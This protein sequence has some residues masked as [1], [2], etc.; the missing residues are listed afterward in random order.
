MKSLTK[1]TEDIPSLSQRPG[2]R[3]RP[4]KQAAQSK[5]PALFRSKSCSVGHLR[6]LSSA[7]RDAH[8]IAHGAEQSRRGTAPRTTLSQ[9]STSGTV[10]RGFGALFPALRLTVT[11]RGWQ[12]DT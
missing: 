3:A 6:A 8:G 4:L 10:P 7:P 2:A 9:D 11:G 12:N 1:L 5:Q